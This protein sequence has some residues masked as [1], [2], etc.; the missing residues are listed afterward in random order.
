MQVSK[1][2]LEP[3]ERPFYVLL[4]LFAAFFLYASGQL[5]EDSL[6]NSM[7]T[8][9]VCVA[10]VLLFSGLLILLETRGVPKVDLEGLW[11]EISTFRRQHFP[12]QLLVFIIVC[13]AYMFAMPV[14][15]F[16]PSTFL[17]LLLSIVYLRRGKV[18]SALIATSISMLLV[19]GMF[20]LLFHIYLP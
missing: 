11:N 1:K 12:P 5:V 2:R 8:I 14:V 7:G 6:I 18:L 16:Y 9:A 17:F 10:L 4:I 20:T 19:Y 13:L 15:G 3:L